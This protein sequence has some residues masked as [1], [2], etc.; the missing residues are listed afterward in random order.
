MLSN[1]ILV[2]MLVTTLGMTSAFALEPKNKFYL[3]A[4]WQTNSL[5]S[6]AIG[7]AF[8]N[9]LHE[10]L[11]AVSILGGYRWDHFG[12]E[13]GRTAFKPVKY[14]IFG[15]GTPASSHIRQTMRN[16]YLDGV[17]YYPLAGDFELKALVGLGLLSTEFNGAGVN[18]NNSGRISLGSGRTTNSKL[19]AR[20]GLG[21]EYNFHENWSSN[22]MYKY[23]QGNDFYKRVDSFALNIAYHF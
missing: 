22:L 2:S 20:L 16:T 8:G 3:G 7:N 9:R 19:G 10:D 12:V 11:T 15:L 6:I 14:Y 13:L 23:Q 5:S 1:K 21:V 18:I 17:V 4:D